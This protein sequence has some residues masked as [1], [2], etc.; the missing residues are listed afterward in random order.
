MI[1]SGGPYEYYQWGE[2]VD[3][4]ICLDDGCY[5]LTVL[6]SWGD[7]ICCD[8]GYGSFDLLTEGGYPFYQADGYFGY[9]S[10]VSFCIYSYKESQRNIASGK[11]AERVGNIT[12]KEDKKVTNAARIESKKADYKQRK[13]SN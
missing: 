3:E 2:T 12:T 6:D 13:A 1:Q 4:P 7:G 5:T 9:S 11:S 10:S 8:Y